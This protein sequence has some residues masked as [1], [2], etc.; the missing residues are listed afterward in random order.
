M[1]RGR[2][3][4]ASRWQ[5]GSHQRRNQTMS[6][7]Y[8]HEI[9]SAFIALAA[10]LLTVS[11]CGHAAEKLLRFAHIYSPEHSAHKAAERLADGVKQQTGGSIEVRVIPS[12]QLGQERQII[13]W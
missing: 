3:A 4:L 11:P 10:V 12:G 1:N 8:V 6:R 7:F 13:E 9:K 5:D 2:R